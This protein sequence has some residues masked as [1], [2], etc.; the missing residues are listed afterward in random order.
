MF[1]SPFCHVA[2][3]LLSGSLAILDKRTLK[4]PNA[5]VLPGTALGL[6]LT[7]NFV[8]C[9]VMF[10][11]GVAFYKFEWECPN[12]RYVERHGNKHGRWR[13]GDVK[14]LAM[15]GAFMGMMAVP[16]LIFGYL[17]LNIY[18]IRKKLFY[19]PIPFAPFIFIASL[20]FLIN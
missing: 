6:Y 16:T 15:L 13:G 5:V 20:P 9:L 12:C 18:R 17:I 14:L 2:F 19:E 11:V 7:H 4:I 1:N 8:W 3:I 10:C